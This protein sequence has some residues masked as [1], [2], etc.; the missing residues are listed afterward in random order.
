MKRRREHGECDTREGGR[1]CLVF[2]TKICTYQKKSLTRVGAAKKWVMSVM[3]RNAA[4]W[5]VLAA[6][7]GAV[8]AFGFMWIRGLAMK[9]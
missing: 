4:L 2:G 7:I 8:L 5:W 9:A 3:K 6:A 1:G